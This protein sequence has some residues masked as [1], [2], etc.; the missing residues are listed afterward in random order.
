MV[1]LT[2]DLIL[3]QVLPRVLKAVLWGSVTFLVVYYLPMMLYPQDLLPIDYTDSLIQ[4]AIISVF[5]TVLG[6]LLSGTIIGCG[7][8][9][10]K[11][12]VIIAFF[13]A[14]S[15]GGIFSLTLPVTEVV[16]NLSVDISTILLM[17]VSVNLFDIAKNLLE[18]IN[19]LTQ[20]AT[21]IDFT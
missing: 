5:F 21:D 17:I 19:I 9:V 8:G 16:I 11:A 2:T 20:K 12:L 3:K 6:Q 15:E 13:F 18:A 1:K 7:F 10:A 4:F 14:I